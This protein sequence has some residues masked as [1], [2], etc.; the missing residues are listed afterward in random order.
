[1]LNM[2]YNF[3]KVWPRRSSVASSL[4]VEEAN[5]KITAVAVKK[6]VSTL[7]SV[8]GIHDHNIGFLDTQL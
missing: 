6:L 2:I 7:A 5:Q 3:G 8:A 1:M 4:K